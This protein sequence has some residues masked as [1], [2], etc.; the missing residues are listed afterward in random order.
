MPPA[1]AKAACAIAYLMMINPGNEIAEN[2]GLFRPFE[3]IFPKEA[4]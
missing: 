2:E 1:S 3:C 4:F